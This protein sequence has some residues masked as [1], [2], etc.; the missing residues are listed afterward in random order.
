[1]THLPIQLVVFDMAGTTVY[2]RD[3][4]AVC[5]RDTV[6]A[7]GITASPE[8]VRAVRGVAKPLAIRSLLERRSA[9]GVNDG[10]VEQLHEQFK[11]RMLA[12]Y[13]SDS[14]VREV[15]GAS[16]A[17]RRLREAGVRVALDSGFSR[18]IVD[19]ILERLGWRRA[20]LIDASVATDEVARG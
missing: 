9:S 2:D 20:G 15:E 16:E 19:A 1:M 18:A 8:A 17:F 4:V 13:R 11:A 14:A 3:T 6:A 5:L 10:L 7:A 12:Y